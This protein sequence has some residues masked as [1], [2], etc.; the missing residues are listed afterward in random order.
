MKG[1]SH[2][3]GSAAIPPLYNLDPS[4]QLTVTTEVSFLDPSNLLTTTTNLSFWILLAAKMEMSVHGPYMYIC[5]WM[6]QIWQFLQT[7]TK[8]CCC[9]TTIDT[10]VQEM[11]DP[12]FIQPRHG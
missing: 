10:N 12:P 2:I 4:N 7:S 8:P 3:S 9:T 1:G 5:T 6:T 11:S